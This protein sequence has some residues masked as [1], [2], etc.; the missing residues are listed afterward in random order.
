[1]EK[2]HLCDCRNNC[3]ASPLKRFIHVDDECIHIDGSRH[4]IKKDEN[5]EV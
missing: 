2:V 5:F 3:P 1:M 4:K